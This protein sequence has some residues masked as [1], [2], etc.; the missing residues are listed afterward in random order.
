LF[1]PASG[2]NPPP[3]GAVFNSDALLDDAGIKPAGTIHTYRK[4]PYHA[5]CGGVVDKQEKIIISY[6]ITGCF[7][8][9]F[10]FRIENFKLKVFRASINKMY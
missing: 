9:N 3:L 7:Q 8:N 5:A 1:I 2:F 6:N 4:Q 10:S